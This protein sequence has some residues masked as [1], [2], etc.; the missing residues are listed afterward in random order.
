MADLMDA[1][2]SDLAGEQEFL[3]GLVA[4]LD[5]AGWATAT[6]SEGWNVA[7]QIS[8]LAYFDHK[9]AQSVTDPE[10]FT[11]EVAAIMASDDPWGL[12]DRI[13]ARGRAMSGTELLGWWRESREGLHSAMRGFEPDRRVPWYGPPMRAYSSA[14]A[15]LMEN[16]A[17]GQD[18]ADA[19]GVE[20]PAT[21]RIYHVAEL[22]IK[23]FSWSFRNRGLEVPD[24][25]VRVVLRGASGGVWVWNPDCDA[26]IT[27]PLRDF[28]LVVTQRRHPSDTRLVIQGGP[29]RRWMQ[30]AQAYAG[31]PGPGRP[32]SED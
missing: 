18:V 25:K 8:H 23:T 15:R 1:V 31:P 29:A 10:A 13:M 22:G 28:C 30:I 21:D 20:Y 4:G 32:P 6:P 27:G 24:R 12:E 3:E 17:H 26:N 14:Q 7:D 19:L 2:V 16:W 9:A 11:A 5:E